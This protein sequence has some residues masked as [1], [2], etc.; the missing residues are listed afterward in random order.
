MTAE[1]PIFIIGSGRSGTTLLR[2]M[3]NA[4]PRIHIAFEPH[5]YWYRSIYRKRRPARE[6]LDYYFQTPHF[7]WQRVD[8]DRVLAELPEKLGRDQLGLAFAAILRERAARY[9]RVR[10]GEK[11]PAHAASLPQIFKDF[12]DARAIHI[13]RDPRATAASLARMPWAP[14]SL[15]LNAGYL[16]LE[17]KQVAKFRDR[18]LMVRLE[19]LLD[20]TRA[21]MT[22]V[23]E[24][25]GEP[26]SDDVLDH[27]AHAP[28]LDDTP[29]YPWLERAGKARD[30]SS[31]RGDAKVAGWGEL[32]PVQIR[33]IEQMTKRL[34]KL[35]GYAKADLARE[36]RWISVFWAG[37]REIPQFFRYA[38]V[39]LPLLY[40]GRVP[41]RLDAVEQELLRRVNPGAWARYPGYQLPSAP[42]LRQLRSG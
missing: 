21:T 19:D 1:S 33:M 15:M 37:V 29:P 12:P 17:R 3:L 26:W 24:F 20:D 25:V 32:T 30:A 2:N 40:K 5:Y 28:D 14:S 34:M 13:V 23:L 22:R 10:I 11:T 18:M 27:A 6:F 35:A 7:R 36:P 16:D 9:G 38:A 4:H 39:G 42:P 8:P 41:E 31:A